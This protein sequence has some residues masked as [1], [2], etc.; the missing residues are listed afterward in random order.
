MRCG[1]YG[2]LP[3]KRDFIAVA[4]PR[5]F[6]NAW[7]PWLQ[8]G[9]SASRMQL[10]AAWQEAYLRAP[11]WRFWLGAEICGGAVLG[12]LM[13]SV[14]GVGRYFPLT[15]FARAE[16]GEALPPPEI[17]PQ[18]AWFAKA[19]D[20]LLSALGQGVPFEAVTSALEALPAPDGA[21]RAAEDLPDGQIRTRDGT[22]VAQ[23][24]SDAFGAVLASLRRQDHA[25][26][27]AAS[28]FWW[29]VGG[30]D[31]APWIVVG[32]RMP[33]PYLFAAMLT[34]RFAESAQ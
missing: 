11:I 15:V 25:R 9:V 6:L 27:Y 24:G 13:P 32:R 12:A 20:L 16:A 23:A 4:T 7:E 28:T 17:D 34:G 31:F 8:G 5:E 21:A 18:E 1:L 26:A 19:E 29:T 3:A 2:K 30:D 33:D 22:L 14:D 10:S